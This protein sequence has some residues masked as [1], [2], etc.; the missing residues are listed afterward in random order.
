M[1]PEERRR[2]SRA[3]P[4]WQGRKYG[5]G[6]VLTWIRRIVWLADCRE[7]RTPARCHD[8]TSNHSAR[9][10]KP[11]HLLPHAPGPIPRHGSRAG[12]APGGSMR[13]P[14]AEMKPPVPSRAESP[15]HS[16]RHQRCANRSIPHPIYQY[17]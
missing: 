17:R 8:M 4:L 10:P 7:L 9:P 2:S 3:S 11:L 14:G 13:T 5:S 12:E 16:S 6:A 1:R 15:H